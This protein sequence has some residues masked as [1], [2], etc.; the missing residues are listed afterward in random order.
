[1]LCQGFRRPEPLLAKMLKIIL[2]GEARTCNQKRKIDGPSE[3]REACAT[4]H[5]F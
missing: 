5:R 1:M 4:G 3:N 2:G